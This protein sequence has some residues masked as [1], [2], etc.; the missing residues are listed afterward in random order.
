MFNMFLRLRQYSATHQ[1]KLS[2]FYPL[3]THKYYRNKCV[4][5]SSRTSSII[6]QTETSSKIYFSISEIVFDH[7]R[8]LIRLDSIYIST[9][10]KASKIIKRHKSLS[11][12]IVYGEQIS[13]FFS[14]LPHL[15]SLKFVCKHSLRIYTFYEKLKLGIFKRISTISYEL[16]L[17]NTNV[18]VNC[19]QTIIKMSL[20]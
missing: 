8:L 14:N 9:Y 11:F 10:F 17:F 12:Q 19:S 20:I 4:L 1:V 6:V 16:T 3:C 15:L 5:H 7:D 18:F 2:Q 13:C